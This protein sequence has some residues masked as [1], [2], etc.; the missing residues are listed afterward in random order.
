[1]EDRISTLEDKQDQLEY[2]VKIMQQGDQ[3]RKGSIEMIQTIMREK[4]DLDR[5]ITN[6]IMKLESEREL[7]VYEI[8]NLRLQMELLEQKYNVLRLELE[9]YRRA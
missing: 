7:H 3:A 8:K 5:E 1:M 4:A 6:R 9:R 2:L